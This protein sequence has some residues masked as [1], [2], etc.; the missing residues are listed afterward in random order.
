MLVLVNQRHFMYH[1]HAKSPI[2][3]RPKDNVMQE[4][5]CHIALSK[6]TGR[7]IKSNLR[8]VAQYL[9]VI[10]PALLF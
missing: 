7:L 2:S 9:C 8:H 5:V 10:W 3:N 6:S 4:S 1:H